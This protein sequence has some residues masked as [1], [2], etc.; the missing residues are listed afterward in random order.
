MILFPFKRTR[1]VAVELRELTLGESIAIC[2]LPASRLEATTTEVLRRIAEKAQEPRP[3][4]VANPRLW[5][6][7]E[8]MLVI[9]HYLSL[10]QDDGPNF[11]IGANAQ[12]SDY[13]TF[14]ADLLVD[15]VQ[16]GVVAGAECTMYPLLG[17]HAEVLEL[18]CESRGDWLLGAMACQILSEAPPAWLEMSDLEL[19]TWV[20][21]RIASLKALPESDFEEYLIGYAAGRQQLFHFFRVD[22]DDAG[23]V[24]KLQGEEVEGRASARFP[25]HT[26][27]GP[28]T[29]S[30]FG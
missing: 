23:V 6:V 12:L 11:A 7:E 19:R 30:L 25:A 29:R 9:A 3:G 10:V 28:A 16:L 17:I 5:T 14:D 27:V 4:Y 18:E 21:E 24:C 22:F 8:R 13:V 26:C 1:R 2:A 15:Q 20:R